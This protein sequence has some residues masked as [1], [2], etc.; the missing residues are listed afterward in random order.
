MK[1]MKMVLLLCA[2]VGLSSCETSGPK[3]QSGAVI[4]A[5]T[6]GLIGSQFGSGG[7]RVAAGVLGAAVGGFIGGSIGAQLDAQDRAR[8]KEIT[9]A[10]IKSG[11]SKSFR[12]AKTGVSGKTKVVRESNAGGKQCRTVQQNVTLANGQVSQDTVTGC[13]GP[14]GWSV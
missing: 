6:G 5:V 14:N 4:G 12:N 13:K 8:L 2:A 3:Q 7:G 1:H 9:T 10:S 11:Q